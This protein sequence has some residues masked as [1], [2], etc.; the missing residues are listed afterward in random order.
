MARRPRLWE[1]GTVYKDTSRTTDRLFLL[2]PTPEIRDIVGS[3]IARALEK[4]PV[5]LHWVDF[6][7]NHLHRGFSLLPHQTE[8]ASRFLQLSNSLIS[9]AINRLYGREG[10]LWSSRA[11]VQPALDDDSVISAMLYSATNVVKDGLVESASHW[12]GLSSYPCLA[13]GKLLRFPYIDWTA[14]R[15]AGGSTKKLP[16]RKFTKWTTIK[17]API[18]AW[19]NLPRDKRQAR[20]RSMVRDYEK[21]LASDIAAQ[22]RSF[23]GLAR[24]SKLDPFAKP[25]EKKPSKP[26]PLCHASSLAT[27]R[28]YE[29][30]WREILTAYREASARFRSG[31]IDVEFPSGMFRPPLGAPQATEEI[32]T[33]P[34]TG[35]QQRIG[36]GDWRQ[37]ASNIENDIDFHANGHINGR[38]PPH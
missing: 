37:A 3:S 6:N 19:K 23:F 25:K 26:A 21:K 24:L 33:R 28:A 20:F 2:K 16:P 38:V 34:A 36:P 27:K 4:Y 15:K 8:N 31:Q 7:V 35:F 32:G 9:R 29:E 17:L 1:P 10:P 5:Q 14:W 11:R 13:H 12:P 18:P 30:H 22:G